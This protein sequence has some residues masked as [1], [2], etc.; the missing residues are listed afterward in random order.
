MHAVRFCWFLNDD[1]IRAEVEKYYEH[2]SSAMLHVFRASNLMFRGEYEL[3]EARTFSRKLLE[4]VVSTGK[5][6]L[7]RQVNCLNFH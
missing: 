4:Q 5:G 2:F 3:K 6:C 1:E 7:L